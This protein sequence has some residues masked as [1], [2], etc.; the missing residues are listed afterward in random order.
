MIGPFVNTAAIVLGGMGGALLGERIPDSLKERMPMIFGCAALGLGVALVVK[1]RYL[2]VPVLALLV[3]TIAGELLHI[4]TQL[5]KLADLVRSRVD[6]WITPKGGTL[7]RDAYMERFIA[8][9][10]IFCAS[11]AGIFGSINEGMT[12]DSS[13]LIAKSFLDFFTAGIFATTL[14]ATVAVLAIPQLT[15][16]SILFFSAALIMP[17]AT[18]DMI[19]D[20]SAVGGLLLLA[21]GLRLL[22]LVSFPLANMLPS[23]L[24]VM[25]LSAFWAHYFVG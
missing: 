20:F 25:P 3:G 14:G 21:T 16:Q 4:E 10:I 9:M 5:E 22:S 18:P 6:K 12:G 17:L 13:L 15:I 23:L 11:G 2:P 7:D 24:I 8:L 1:V 19:A